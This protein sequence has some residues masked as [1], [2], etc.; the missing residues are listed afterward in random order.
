MVADEPDLAASLYAHADGVI[1]CSPRMS[2]DGL[3]ALAAGRPRLLCVNRIPQ[4]GP[5]PG[6]A[7][8]TFTP[9]FE[10]CRHLAELGHRRV[11]YFAGAPHSWVNAERWRAVQHAATLGL[12]PLRSRPGRPSTPATPPPTPPSPSARRP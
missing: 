10:M 1:L 7:C 11:V 2:D 3:A 5:P 4:G 6:V 9:M 8:D 12:E